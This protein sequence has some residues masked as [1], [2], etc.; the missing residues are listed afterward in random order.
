V[1]TATKR[2]NENK[3]DKEATAAMRK[4]KRETPEGRRFKRWEQYHRNKYK[5]ECKLFLPGVYT[6]E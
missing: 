6:F 2:N 4:W 1:G 3:L 5:K